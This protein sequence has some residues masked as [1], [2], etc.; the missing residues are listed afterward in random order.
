V[1]FFD[2]PL[3]TPGMQLACDDLLLDA[4]DVD[5]AK[6]TLR[7]WQ[8]ETYFV[9]AGY[10]NRIMQEVHVDTCVERGIP[11]YRRTSGGGTVVQG[12]GCFNYSLVLRMERDSALATVTSTNAY[13][14]QRMAEL[15]SG[16][17]GAPV[18][19]RG[20]TDLVW[21][22][23]KFSGN[24]QRRKERA[25]LFHGTFLLSFDLSMIEV[26]LPHPSAEPDYR[27]G[28]PHTGFLTNLPLRTNTL[29]TALRETWAAQDAYGPFPLEP[30]R[31]LAETRYLNHEWTYRF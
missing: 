19:H 25:L 1:R 29:T 24:A 4:C 28:R 27:T 3:A 6:E 16:L 12:P 18:E 11:L 15:V 30:V 13:V 22:N 23:R 9:V 31:A 14:L 10:T 26:L 20:H 8:P 7:I 17:L 21:N 5:P 2:V